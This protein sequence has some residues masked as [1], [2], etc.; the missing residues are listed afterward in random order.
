M[1]PLRITVEVVG[2]DDEIQMMS[3][4]SQVFAIYAEKLDDQSMRRATEWF[5]DYSK[6]QC[7]VR[8]I[9]L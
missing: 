5:S 7:P 8:E 4:L 6:G 1:E 3:A 2:D 9:R